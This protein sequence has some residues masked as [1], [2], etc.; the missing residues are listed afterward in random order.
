MKK[1]LITIAVVMLAMT[2][3]TGC[4]HCGKKGAD[5]G[6]ACKGKS[7]C[8][9]HCK[10]YD[11]ADCAKKCEGKDKA[12]CAKKCKGHEKAC[13]EH[14]G[15]A[16]CCG[17]HAPDAQI[18]CALGGCKVAAKD[19]VKIGEGKYACGHCAGAKKAN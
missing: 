19:A 10:G 18:S 13:C 6:Y 3:L 1:T 14:A 2:A 17:K 4:S 16:A 5:T 15:T 11:R 12:E 9:S 8:A 7:A